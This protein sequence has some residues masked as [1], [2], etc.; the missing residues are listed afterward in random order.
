M[1]RFFAAGFWILCGTWGFFLVTPARGQVDEPAAVEFELAPKTISRSARP[2]WSLA[3]SPEG[4]R[5]AAGNDAGQILLRNPITQETLHVLEGHEGVVSAVAFAPSGDRLASA[6]FDG[7]IRLWDR[8]S[9]RLEFTLTGHTNW[10]TC[11][12]FSPDG[13]ALASAGYDKSVRV[14][15]AKTGVQTDQFDGHAATVRSLTFSPDGTTLVSA[16]DKGVLDFWNQETGE[17]RNP[18]PEQDAGIQTVDFSPDGKRLLTVPYDGKI[19][20]WDLSTNKSVKSFSTASPGQ[21]DATP[22]AACFSSDGS[23]VLV[24]DRGGRARVWSM[25][26][27]KLLQILD[28]HEDAATALALSTDGKTLYTAGL[29]GKILAWPALLPL[30]PPLHKL[31]IPVGPVWDLAISPD[32]K[33]LAVGGKGGFVE[34][35]DLTTGRQR[36]SLNG[37]EATVD[38]L[39]FSQDGKLIAVAGWRSEKFLAW[40]I[41][42]GEIEHNLTLESNLRAFAISPDGKTLA[43]GYSKNSAIALHS[44]PEGTKQKE[45]AGHDLPVYDLVFS[46]DGDR[47]ASCSGEWT[48]RKPGRVVIHDA[49]DGEKL[50]QF[51]DHSHAVRSLDVAESGS[52]LYSISQDGV[53]KVYDMQGL[54]ESRTFQNGLA[55]RPLA[56]SPAGKRVAVG[57]QNGNI[58]LWNLETRE[59]EHR[60]QGTDDLFAV[61]FSRDGSLLVAADGNEFVQIWK[62]SDD[63]NSLARTVPSWIPAIAD[64]P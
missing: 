48:E 29:D 24:S 38:C 25:K 59:I 3:V 62:L 18:L 52:R 7:K 61:E 45:L 32:G 33:T 9:G 50:A 6:G 37:F 22:Q 4:K 20:I 23:S 58:N 63:E 64:K 16:D 41:T 14:W 8:A 36:K 55:A 11:L 27:G 19:P 39:Q 57:L 35:W 42:T 28:G 26:T 56:I 31:P 51:D 34:L 1:G 54:R 40:D 43:V 21:D 46:P 53:L 47:L 5:L 13:T 12:E 44:L 2:I 60:F 49:S 15:N 30:E 17:H 10:I